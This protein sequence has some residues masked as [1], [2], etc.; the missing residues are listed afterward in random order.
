MTSQQN[1]PDNEEDGEMFDGRSTVVTLMNLGILK[2]CHPIS[3]LTVFYLHSIIF[4]IG[5]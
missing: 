5:V 2:G 3:C 4:K 1:V